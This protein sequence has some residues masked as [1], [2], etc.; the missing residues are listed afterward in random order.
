MTVRIWAT[1]RTLMERISQ[2]TIYRD[3]GCWEFHGHWNN[4]GYGQVE[5]QGRLQLVHRIAFKL[6][7]GRI[8]KG[9]FVLHNCDNSKCYNPD[10]LF[11]GTQADNMADMR[12]KGRDNDWGRKELPPLPIEDKIHIK[13]R[14]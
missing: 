3:N 13:R 12:A 11:I 5:Y 4:K 1:N 7:K 9:K 14:L 2:H 6:M 8:P 10:H